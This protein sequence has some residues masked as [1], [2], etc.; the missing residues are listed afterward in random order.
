MRCKWICKIQRLKRETSVNAQWWFVVQSKVF[1]CNWILQNNILKKE[2]VRMSGAKT[3]V[4]RWAIIFFQNQFSWKESLWSGG[5]PGS[6]TACLA[7]RTFAA[8]PAQRLS[9]QEPGFGNGPTKGKRREKIMPYSPLL[10]RK[11]ISDK[12]ARDGSPGTGASPKG[13]GGGEWRVLLE[14]PSGGVRE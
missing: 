6:A 11:P 3:I 2:K 9:P 7:I 14:N 8:S 1:C 13:K 5:K 12:A 10:N 4:C